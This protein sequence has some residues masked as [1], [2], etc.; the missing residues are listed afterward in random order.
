[1]TFTATVSP[2]LATGT[3]TGTVTFTVNGVT[4]AGDARRGRRGDVHHA[5]RSRPA[6][7]TITADYGGDAVFQPSSG[8]VMQTVEQDGHH[9]RRGQ[10]PKPVDG[11]PERDVHRN[12]EPSHGHRNRRL[13]HRRHVAPWPWS[14]ARPPSR[15]PHWRSAAHVI[16]ASYGGDASYLGSTSATFTQTVGP[17]L[18][19][20]TTV[21]TSNRVPSANF[22][23]NVT[24][25]ATVRPVTG[26]GIPGGTVQFNIDGAN[27]G[28]VLALNAQGRAT[29]TT[30]T[31]V[32]RQPQRHRHLQRLGDLRR[33]QQRTFVQVVNQAASTRR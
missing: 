3:P 26:T 14:L 17:V 16:G 11:R 15:P 28:G 1:M 7:L 6:R 21:V 9:D 24:F 20:T 30:N 32:G 10:Q 31:P 25:T 2:V 5:T 22:G 19:A 13:Q 18:R 4:H 8:S 27:V 33:R 12:G 23:Q 29:F